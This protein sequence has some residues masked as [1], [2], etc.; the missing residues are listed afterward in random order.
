MPILLDL[1]A[2]DKREPGWIHVDQ[3]TRKEG[4]AAPE[5]VADISKPLPFPDNYADEIRSIHVVEH[6]YRWEIESI[7]TDWVRVLKPG[8]TM[9]LECP[10]LTACMYF[11]MTTPENAQLGILGVFGDPGY[12]E[13]AMTH[14]WCYTIGELAHIMTKAGLT[15]IVRETPKFHIPKRDLRLVGT[16]SFASQWP[17]ETTNVN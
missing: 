8:G 11:M 13:V 15:N 14:K 9:A 7:L 2:G 3:V 17:I 12:K 16:K 4:V 1:G 6:M 5:V 10:D